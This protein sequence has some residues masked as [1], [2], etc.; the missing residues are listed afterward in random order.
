MA[1][2]FLHSQTFR[3]VFSNSIYWLTEYLNKTNSHL[4]YVHK[5][6]L[7]SMY[8]QGWETKDISDKFSFKSWVKTA[9]KAETGASIEL[10]PQLGRCG[11][12]THWSLHCSAH[13]CR[14]EIVKSRVRRLMAKYHILHFEWQN[15][16]N[17]I[18]SCH[19]TIT[20]TW[21]SVASYPSDL[22]FCWAK[23]ALPQ[24]RKRKTPD[25][26]P[27]ISTNNLTIDSLT[28]MVPAHSCHIHATIISLYP[29]WLGLKSKQLN[30][31]LRFRIW[32][33]SRFLVSAVLCYKRRSL[34]RKVFRGGRPK[35]LRTYCTAF[36]I[37]QL[38]QSSAV[39][40]IYS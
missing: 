20:P 30:C 32:G 33:A 40:Y 26:D 23:A 31:V 29:S 22:S 11:L 19:R 16:P 36:S 14:S 6:A 2:N 1:S 35:I 3:F 8:C 37:S 18:M 34:I 13:K 10:W 15:Q 25:S 12:L 28:G 5:N 7:G 39:K 4:S 24:T 38:N 17:V 27:P 9:S 21:T